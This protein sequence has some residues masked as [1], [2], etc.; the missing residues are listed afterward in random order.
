MLHIFVIFPYFYVALY[1]SI[2]VLYCIK[3]KLFNVNSTFLFCALQDLKKP[4]DKAW[5]DYET[6]V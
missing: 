5:K 2:R 1:V 4:F 6:K 3:V